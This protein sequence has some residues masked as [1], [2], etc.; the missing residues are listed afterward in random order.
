MTKKITIVLVVIAVVVGIIFINKER[1]K[2]ENNLEANKSNMT[3]EE[4]LKKLGN[5][6]KRVNYFNSNYIDRYLK[7]K[8]NNRNMKNSDIVLQVNIGLDQEFY[9]NIK[10]ALDIDTTYVLVNK[11]YY[12]DE[13]Y[14]P[15]NLETIDS[16]YS[17]PG[18]KMV[19]V[20]RISFEYLAKKALSE[21]YRIRA[22]ST[23]RSFSYQEGLYNNYVAKDGVEKA[24][25][26]SAR[27]GFSEH[28]TGLAVDVDNFSTSFNDFENTKEYKW[29]L[30]N[31]YK[32]GF[33][34]RYPKD[35]ENI[36]GYIYEPWH[37][38]Y[39]GIEIASLIHENNLSYEEYYFKY[40]AK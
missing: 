19:N 31:A 24:D 23:Y 25:K 28:Q 20:A 2:K 15:K 39:V 21:G 35:K 26:Y 40:I 13:N 17:V 22:V 37:Y 5:V 32:Y 38:R 1:L 3:L 7:Y 36:T 12:L 18:K 14:I 27:A 10:R 34:L 30:D 8:E 16:N 4:K 33:I 6:N 11:F 29:M 9:T